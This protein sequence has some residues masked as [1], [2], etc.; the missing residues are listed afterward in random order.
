MYK[1]LVQ[2]CRA[3]GL[4]QGQ[5]CRS[6]ARLLAMAPTN[7]KHNISVGVGGVLQDLCVRFLDRI[8]RQDLC[9]G[10]L[11]RPSTNSK[12]ASSTRACEGTLCASCARSLEMISMKNQHK[13]LWSGFYRISAPDVLIGSPGKICVL[14][15][16]YRS[17]L[18]KFCREHPLQDL[19]Q[20]S[21]H[22]S[23][24]VDVCNLHHASPRLI[25]PTQSLQTFDASNA[26]NATATVPEHPKGV[27]GSQNLA[28]C[29]SVPRCGPCVTIPSRCPRCCWGSIRETQAMSGPLCP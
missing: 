29:A 15:P 6:C 16:P 4:A 8:S 20:G 23:C 26:H 22:R 13:S 27:W 1:F 17:S 18:S 24:A 11:K 19:L 10:S 7:D 28:V 3:Q 12:E 25:S 2:I 5:F 9:T 14:D 21:L